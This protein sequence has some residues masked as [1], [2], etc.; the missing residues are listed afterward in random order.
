[1][2]SRCERRPPLCLTFVNLLLHTIA[3]D[4][5][6]STAELTAPL[7]G[8]PAFKAILAEQAVVGHDSGSSALQTPDLAGS[9]TGQ[10]HFLHKLVLL[11]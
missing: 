7:T 11:Q 5:A 4:E 3:A 8:S 1:M 10:A 2:T 9:I 6:A